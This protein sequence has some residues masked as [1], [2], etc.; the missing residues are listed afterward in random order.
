MQLLCTSDQ[1]EFIQIALCT[2]VSDYTSY[3]EKIS[4]KNQQTGYISI[5]LEK[6]DNKCNI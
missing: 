5:L 2:N 1:M 4:L 3:S 6:C